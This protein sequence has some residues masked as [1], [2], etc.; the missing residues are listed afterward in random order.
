MYRN[1]STY[2]ER[3]EKLHADYDFQEILETY[4][5]LENEDIKAALEYATHLFYNVFHYRILTTSNTKD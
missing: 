5:A 1:S 2:Y 3:I 4:P